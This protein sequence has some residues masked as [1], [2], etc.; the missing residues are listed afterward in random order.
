MEDMRTLILSRVVALGFI[1]SSSANVT[2]QN[3]V[4]NSDFDSG[5]TGWSGGTLFETDGSPSTPSYLVTSPDHTQQAAY[6]GCFVLDHTRLYGFTAQG[7]IIGGDFG[8]FGSIQVV[9]FQDSACTSLAGPGYI[10]L[11]NLIGGINDNWTT[12]ALPGPA[13]VVLLDS[14]VK[15]GQILLVAN[16]GISNPSNVL[17]DHI[18]LEPAIFSSD[19]ESP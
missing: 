3:V 10:A 17:F 5:S 15:S 1:V 9:V 4:P 16:S 13:R 2:A 18:V 6:S 8:D 14:N 7:R 12:I 11:G 19:F